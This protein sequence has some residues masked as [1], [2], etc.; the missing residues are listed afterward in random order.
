MTDQSLQKG[1][2]TT[3][4]K[5]EPSV[6]VSLEIQHG[7]DHYKSLAIQP[8]EYCHR[9]HFRFCESEA[10]KY[11]SRFRAKNGAEDLRKAIHF[12]SMILDMEYNV[13]A[14]TEYVDQEPKSNGGYV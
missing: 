14:T 10:I 7:G 9:N 13:T 8:A 4:A 6:P 5:R 2:G 1:E 3:K 12:A 11:L